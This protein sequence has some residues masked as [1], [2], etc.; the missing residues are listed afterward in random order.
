MN[1]LEKKVVIVTG[2]A[3]G[4][5]KATVEAFA[6]YGSIV[7]IW[8]LNEERGKE[9]EQQLL[10]NGYIAHFYKVNT[11]DSNE[12]KSAVDSITE[13]YGK[14][15]VLINN[16]GITKD[17]SLL[18]MTDDQWDQVIDVN[19]KGVFNCTKIIAPIMV[20]NG[21]GRIINASSVVGLYGNF[22]QTNYAAT[23][24]GVIAMTKT[25]AKELGKKG[26]N[27]NAV[28]PGFILTEMVQAMPE[29]VLDKMKEKVPVNR[30]GKPEDIAN[31]YCFLASDLANYIN[32]ATISVDG[33]ITL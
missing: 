4:I 29:A 15:D 24:A 6:E 14:V 18:K 30:L 7:N 2:G 31:I 26:V 23:K 25:W 8:D 32:G 27:V 20:A 22:G 28:A 13:K 16:A 21:F 19:L 5:G 11:T 10:N 9:L 3:S 17:A 33:G 1:S 12:I